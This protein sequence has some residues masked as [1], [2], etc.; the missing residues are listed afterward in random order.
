MYFKPT[1]QESVAAGMRSSTWCRLP[2][3]SELVHGSTSIPV[4]RPATLASNDLAL[5]LTQTLYSTQRSLEDE[6]CEL[7]TLKVTI[8]ISAP[9]SS[10]MPAGSMLT[11]LRTGERGPG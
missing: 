2:G 11:R 6:I 7:L 3:P 10:Q 1:L 9:A 8:H 5:Y 4:Q